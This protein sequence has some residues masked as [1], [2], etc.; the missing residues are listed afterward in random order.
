[1]CV[2]VLNFHNNWYQ[3][4]FLKKRVFDPNSKIKVLK[5]CFLTYHRVEEEDTN[6]LV[7][8]RWRTDVLHDHTRQH[9]PTTALPTRAYTHHSSSS[10]YRVDPP[11]QPPVSSHANN[12]AKSF[13]TSSDQSVDT[14]TYATPA[15]ITSAFSTSAKGGPVLITWIPRH[16]ATSSLWVLIQCC[17]DT[18]LAWHTASSAP[19]VDPK[20]WLIRSDPSEVRFGWSQC[21]F[22][23]FWPFRTHL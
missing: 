4:L 1:M 9:A 18:I 5:T 13:D 16:L 19:F 23:Y 8:T 15:T 20:L 12:Y 14:S 6:P 17:T 11:R 7:K 22:Q 21:R 10:P 3:S 2:W